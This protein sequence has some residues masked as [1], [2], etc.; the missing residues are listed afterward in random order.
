LADG[1][2][3]QR[4]LNVSLFHVKHFAVQGGGSAFPLRSLASRQAM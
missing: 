4:A 1:V 2:S 3:P